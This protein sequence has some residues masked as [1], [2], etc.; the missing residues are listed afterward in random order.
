MTESHQ[1]P[2][3]TAYTVLRRLDKALREGAPV[4]SCWELL[5]DV[6]ARDAETAID[7]AYAQDG[8]YMAIPRRFVNERKVTTK[9]ETRR[10]IE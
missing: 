8:F 10:V 1:G 5:K 3:E 7:K 9:T 4:E 2:H 6:S